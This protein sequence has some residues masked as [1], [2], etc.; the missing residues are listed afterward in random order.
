ARSGCFLGVSSS[1]VGE[2]TL[3]S[4]GPSTGRQW[5]R[6]DFT[7][8]TSPQCAFVVRTAGPSREVLDG[9]EI[10]LQNLASS[11]VVGHCDGDAN[12]HSL[13]STARKFDA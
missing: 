10:S 8:G 3:I 12:P 13:V 4:A 2:G 6:A 1:Q 7:D 5:V 9:C 11:Q